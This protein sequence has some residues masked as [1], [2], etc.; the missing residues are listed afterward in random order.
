MKK[1]KLALIVVGVSLFLTGCSTPVQMYPFSGSRAD[2]SI[3][4]AYNYRLFEKPEVNLMQAKIDATRK[5]QSWGYD[6][7][8]P[9]GGKTKRCVERSGLGCNETEVVVEY[10]C[11]GDLHNQ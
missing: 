8:E 4:M 10:Q 6:S 1:Y 9:F 7:A 5:C 2:G 3:K 11:L